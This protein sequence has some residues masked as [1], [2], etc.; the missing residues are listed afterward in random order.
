[1]VC[2]FWVEVFYGFKQV[3]MYSNMH[4][5]VKRERWAPCVLLYLYIA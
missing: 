2:L 5:M 1:V 4:I 3:S